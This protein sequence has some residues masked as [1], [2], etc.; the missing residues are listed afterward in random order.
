M[1]FFQPLPI[2][3]DKCGWNIHFYEQFECKRAV[4]AHLRVKEVKMDDSTVRIPFVVLKT[5]INGKVH[6]LYVS[7]LKV[8]FGH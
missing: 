6:S 3:V 2:K 1:D 5:G 4:N 7:R 8:A